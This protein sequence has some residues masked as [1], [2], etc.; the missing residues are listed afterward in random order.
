MTI[1]TRR[2]GG[3]GNDLINWSY[4]W[5]DTNLRL[6]RVICTN[7]HATMWTRVT[8]TVRAN[9]RTFSA[10]VAP[11]GTPSNQLPADGFAGSLSQNIPTGAA[12]RLSLTVQPVT[13]R[14]DGI[15]YRLRC[16]DDVR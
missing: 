5:D 2:L 12:A 9:G 15:D 4:E 8:A 14:P 1:Q 13:G 11:A 3:C 10:V 16:G 7:T 6:T